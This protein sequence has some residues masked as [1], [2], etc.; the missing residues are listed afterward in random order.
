MGTSPG[1]PQPHPGDAATCSSRAEGRGGLTRP[2][3]LRSSRAPRAAVRRTAAR[4]LRFPRKPLWIR[5][6]AED[7]ELGR[8][9]LNEIKEVLSSMGLRLGMVRQVALCPAQ[10]CERPADVRT[11]LTPAGRRRISRR[12]RR[13][14]SGNCSD[15]AIRLQVILGVGRETR[16]TVPPGRPFSIAG[17]DSLRRNGVLL[18]QSE[19]SYG[20]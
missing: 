18:P 5:V 20:K 2:R 1:R 15:D 8:K 6:N 3:L 7:A 12:G 19:G 9:S 17:A 4:P 10:G 11:C 13:S 14:W 16:R